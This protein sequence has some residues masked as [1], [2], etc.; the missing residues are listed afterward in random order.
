VQKTPYELSVTASDLSAFNLA[1]RRIFFRPICP[2][3]NT[4]SFLL[5]VTAFNGG[6]QLLTMSAGEPPVEL[7][8][9]KGPAVTV[10]KK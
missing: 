5:N 9:G 1:L 2:F 4:P 10:I 6:G 7:K 3:S 8:A